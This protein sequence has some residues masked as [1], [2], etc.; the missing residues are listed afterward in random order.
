MFLNN[1]DHVA[2]EIEAGA[3]RTASWARQ[4]EAAMAAR[5]GRSTTR[6]RSAVGHALINLG[7]LI[8]AEPA[9]VRTQVGVGR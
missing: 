5:K 6:T 8:A 7:R 2:H 3:A 1:V 4:Y 9:P